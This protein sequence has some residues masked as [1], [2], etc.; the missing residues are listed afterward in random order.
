MQ[1]MPDSVSTAAVSTSTE[2]SLSNKCVTVLSDTWPILRI[3]VKRYRV[4]FNYRSSRML[5]SIISS[6]IEKMDWGTSSGWNSK[7]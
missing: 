3:D 2:D 7:V 5:L 6:V 4:V 1:S